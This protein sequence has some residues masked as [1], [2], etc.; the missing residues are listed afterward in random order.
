[1]SNSVNFNN[2][3]L[4]DGIKILE[5]S[6]IG[7]VP[8]GVSILADLGAT[9]TRII[10][11]STST[12]QNSS[13]SNDIM[14]ERGRQNVYLNLKNTNDREKALELIKEHDILI[15]GMR[16]GVME[17]LGLS[18]SECSKVNPSLVYTRVTGWGQEGPLAPRAGHD[19]NYIALSGV[20]NAIGPKENP[21][22][23]LN[24]VGDYGGGG[25]FMIIGI[26]S[27]LLNSKATKEGSVLDIA[28][29]DGAIRQIGIAY[30]RYAEGVWIDKRSS[31]ILDGGAPWY[32]VYKTKCGG[33][34]AV[35]AIEPQFYLEL[36]MGL[37]LNP[38]TL[39]E[40]HNRD[41]W[42]ELKTIFEQRFSTKTR[43][44]WSAIFESTDACVTPVL[45]LSEAPKHPHNVFRKAFITAN[46]G[47]K[48]PACA[49]RASPLKDN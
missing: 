45:S 47:H 5:F 6:A 35:G 46:S 4:L 2:S 44:E 38:D 32:N 24:L 28:M 30:E 36:L 42:S 22:I 15:E 11:A 18:P 13:K 20:L 1:M 9:V 33:F 27:A 8:W 43:K 7:P 25:A 40:R 26:L 10:R 3:K 19:I 48:L 41:N 29:V 21:V 37:E 34:M 14:S 49:P 17:R 31:N 12:P 23:P 16:P 39:P